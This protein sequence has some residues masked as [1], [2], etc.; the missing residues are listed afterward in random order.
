MTLRV[1]QIHNKI[2]NLM[3]TAEGH[4]RDDDLQAIFDLIDDDIFEK[5]AEFTN[6]LSS[7]VSEVSFVCILHSFSYFKAQ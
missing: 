4:T 6:L 1:H 5:D 2:R 3:E 7:N